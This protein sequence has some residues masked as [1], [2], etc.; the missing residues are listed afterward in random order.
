M[1]Q[2]QFFDSHLKS[3]DIFEEGAKLTSKFAYHIVQEQTKIETKTKEIKLIKQLL[4]SVRIEHAGFH[5]LLTVTLSLLL[6]RSVGSLNV[7]WMS[8]KINSNA[9]SIHHILYFNNFSYF[10]SFKLCKVYTKIY[11]TP[12]MA[13]GFQIT[14]IF[15]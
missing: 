2:V 3:L 7:I 13:L 1:K 12:F 6:I 15:V 10:R 5:T 4:Q 14:Q 9:M 11:Q 8:E